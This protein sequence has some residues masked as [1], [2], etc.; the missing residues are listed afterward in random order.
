M[1][2]VEI[3]GGGLAG[4]G[5]G[6]ALRR[7]SVPATIHEAG[8]YPRH[9]VCGEFIT[10]LDQSTRENL[11]LDDILRRARPAHSVSWCEDGEAD[12]VHQLPHPALCLSR[13]LLDKSMAETFVELG[14]ELRTGSRGQCNDEP[15]RVHACGRKPGAPSRWVGI[16]QHFRGLVMEKDLEVHFARGGY[17]G[18]TKVEDGTMNVC[19]L[20][21]RGSAD[22]RKPFATIAAQSGFEKL[23]HRLTEAAPLADSFCAVASLDYGATE[24]DGL[25]HIGDRNALIPPFTGNGMTIALQSAVAAS[26]P[27]AAWSRGEI[28]WPLARKQAMQAQQ[29]QFGTRWRTARALHPFVLH[30]GVRSLARALHKLGVLPV[31]MLYRLMH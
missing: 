5:L 7:N 23:S 12:I 13:H 27:L 2:R 28:S 1:L 6:I 10:S 15:G 21:K 30:A 24:E 17:I 26:L 9:R 4:L 18:V 11:Q 20:L 3:I 25:L 16:K 31:A 8:H 29:R 19:G 22:L 14:G